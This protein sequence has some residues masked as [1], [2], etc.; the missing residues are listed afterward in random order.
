MASNEC[1][2]EMVKLLKE[3]FGDEGGEQENT[4]VNHDQQVNEIIEACQRRKKCC[5]KV[6][7]DGK[8]TMDGGRYK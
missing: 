6:C 8:S 7:P 5:C 2:D 1:S 4:I 3:E